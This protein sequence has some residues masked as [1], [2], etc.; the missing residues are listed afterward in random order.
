MDSSA[1]SGGSSAVVSVLVLETLLLV[2][3]VVFGLWAY[4]SRQHYK[5]NVDQQISTAVSAA[6]LKTQATDANNYAQQSKSPLVTYVGPQAYGSITVQYPKTW[7]AY[8]DQTGEGGGLVNGFF[9]PGFVPAIE[10][11]TSVF[12]L[13]VEVLQQPYNQSL[14]QFNSD[15]MNGT[16][17]VAAYALPKLPNVV[18]IEVKGNIGNEQ[19]GI[20]VVLPLRNNTL[21]IWTSAPQYESDFNT[22]ILPNFS[23]SP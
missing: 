4:S 19:T 9:N 23:F 20:M 21:E 13:R 6:V 16:G 17:T 1:D 7:S 22:Y 8:V 18:G 5:N 15:A 10:A 2:V 12:A 14:A 11:E 3:L